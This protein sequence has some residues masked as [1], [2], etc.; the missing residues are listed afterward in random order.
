[1]AWRLAKSLEVLRNQINA[2]WPVRDKSNDGT[3]GDASHQATT[4]DHN[5]NAAGVVTAMDI[6]RDVAHG[7]DS[8]AVAQQLL[9]SRDPRIKYIISDGQICNSTVSPWVWR[10]YTG[11]DPHDH[12]FHIS[13]KADATLWDDPRPWKFGVQGVARSGKGGWYSQFNGKFKWVDEGDAPGSAA[14]G[15]P[16]DAQGVSFFDKATLGKW[17]FVTAPNGVR[18]LEQQ[19]DIGPAPATGRLIDISAAAAERFGYS[20]ANFPTDKIFS[21]EPT[22]P[23]ASVASLSPQQQAVAFRD[24]RRAP[25]V[26]SPPPPP[27]KE[28]T[29]MN[30]FGFLPLLMRILQILPQIQ[31]AMKSG[32]SIFVL[33]QK[34]APDL[35]SILTGIGG[36]LF[37]ELPAPSQTQIGGLMMDP[38]KIRVIQTQLNKLGA[39]P[40]LETDGL[41]GAKTKAAVIAF[42]TAHNVVPA[43]G[44]PGDQTT[45]ALQTE[46]SKLTAVVPPAA[47][48]PGPTLSLGIPSA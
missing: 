2:Q 43:D 44:W 33:L 37:P 21:W 46:V 42:Q 31:E 1:M 45:A 15:V 3:I 23:P 26:A 41:L 9:D 22:A 14:L 18:S 16:D 32:T 27:T 30:L 13:V 25:V 19:T 8:R 40:Q 17:F 29:E 7:L 28:T 39:N 5:P 36:Q 34:F 6:T 4:S 35:I 38:A 47:P 10:K 12:H 11:A 48:A 20:P 24:L